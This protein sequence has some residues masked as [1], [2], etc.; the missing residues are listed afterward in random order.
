MSTETQD[1]SERFMPD[2]RSLDD[3]LYDLLAYA[4]Q[5]GMYDAADW[6]ATCRGGGGDGQAETVNRGER[7]RLADQLN[8]VLNQLVKFRSIGAGG[9]P[10]FCTVCDGWDGAHEKG[11]SVIEISKVRAAL[12]DHDEDRDPDSWMLEWREGA[13]LV[14]RKGELLSNYSTLYDDYASAERARQRLLMELA[15]ADAEG[16]VRI[17][18]VYFNT[19]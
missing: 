14:W 13:H 3:Q 10:M 15:T 17:R 19:P 11:C 7:E 16:E 9:A 8:Q 1:Q 5:R 4:V 6:L 2:Q 12:L 18:T